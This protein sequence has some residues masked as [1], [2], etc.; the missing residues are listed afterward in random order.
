MNKQQKKNQFITF[1]VLRHVERIGH[2][3]YGNPRKMVIIDPIGRSDLDVFYT[4]PNSSLAY[5]ISG[6]LYNEVKVTASIYR[7]KMCIDS[8]EEI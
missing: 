6:H 1:G 2:S 4:R 3:N 7:G 8:I 5:S